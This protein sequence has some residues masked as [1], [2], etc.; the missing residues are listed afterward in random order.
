MRVELFKNPE[1]RKLLRN[2]IICLFV[3]V[4]L[5]TVCVLNK[6]FWAGIIVVILG[7]IAQ[8][9]YV[10][11]FAKYVYGRLYVLTFGSEKIMGGNYEFRID[12]DGEGELA[13]LG[14]QFNQMSK[15]LKLTLEQLED[16]K[17]TLKRWISDMSHQLKTPLAV[18]HMYN[19]ILMQQLETE[20]QLDDKL[21]K[22]LLEKNLRQ[23]EGMEW[24]I[25]SVLKIS[26]LQSGIIELNKNDMD[27]K[28]TLLIAVE[29]INCNSNDKKQKISFTVPEGKI[30]FAHDSM[31]LREALKNILQNAVTYTDIEGHIDVSINVTDSLIKLVIKDNGHGISKEELPHIFERFYRGKAAKN[32]SSG[33]GVGLALSK[34]IVELHEGIIGIE[35]EEEAGTVVTIIFSNLN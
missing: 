22:E 31:W 8:F 30:I 16:E 4:A 2:F 21:M 9:F 34:L 28:Q 24:L 5:L 7:F 10:H 17:Q 26:R 32:N 18:I 35:S 15:R 12:E 23:I 1:Y 25:Q 19:E 20:E 3:V 27:L 6:K 33:T 14:F 13:I 29:D 11:V